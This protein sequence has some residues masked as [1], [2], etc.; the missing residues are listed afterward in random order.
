ML[1]AGDSYR[2]PNKTGLTLLTGNAGALEV[3]VDGRKVPALGPGGAIRRDV[4]LD[5]DRLMA[6]TAVDN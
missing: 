4:A 1:R 6:G 3:Y 5:A 2:V